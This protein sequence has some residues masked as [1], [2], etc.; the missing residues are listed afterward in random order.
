MQY[1]EPLLFHLFQL[2]LQFFEFDIDYFAVLHPRK[3]YFEYFTDVS[4]RQ[5][6]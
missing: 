4:E 6:H 3:H 5:W 2:S 1:Q